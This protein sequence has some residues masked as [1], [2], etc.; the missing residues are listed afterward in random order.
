M[1]GKAKHKNAA[2][3]ARVKLTVRAGHLT[4]TMLFFKLCIDHKSCALIE[5]GILNQQ[6][7]FHISA[8]CEIFWD[9]FYSLP[10]S[11]YYVFSVPFFPFVLR[12]RL[13]CTAV[14]P[15]RTPTGA[16][17]HANSVK[18][19]FHLFFHLLSKVAKHRLKANLPIYHCSSMIS[20]S[21]TTLWVHSKAV[22]S[23]SEQFEGVS[24]R[25]REG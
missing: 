25:K 9:R 13:L 3:C 14:V 15:Q 8:I 16:L 10:L 20:V 1:V 24:K 6:G 17:C 21:V 5:K 19:S 23:R 2:N 12:L 4:N 11:V 22:S 18:Q 7:H